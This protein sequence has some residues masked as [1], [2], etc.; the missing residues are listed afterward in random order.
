MRKFTL[1]HKSNLNGTKIQ[2]VKSRI[3]PSLPLLCLLLML[4]VGGWNSE[5]WGESYT[6]SLANT[7]TKDYTKNGEIKLTFSN[8]NKNSNGFALS[9]NLLLTGASSKDN[10]AREGQVV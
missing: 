4:I 3:T 10:N 7:D 5:I 6:V 9:K 8:V 2:G 1:L